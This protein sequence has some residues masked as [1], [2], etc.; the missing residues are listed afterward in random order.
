MATSLNEE[1]FT[2]NDILKLNNQ[3]I[4]ELLKVVDRRELAIALK[5]AVDEIKKRFILL[6]DKKEEES[7][8]NMMFLLGT[9]NVKEIERA[10][11]YIIQEIYRLSELGII[12]YPHN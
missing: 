11:R 12:S 6:M 9:L 10:K 3:E 1:I 5:G 8:Y 7:F 2:F 4:K